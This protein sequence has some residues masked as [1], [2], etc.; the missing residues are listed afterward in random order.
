MLFEGVLI[1]LKYVKIIFFFAQFFEL[2]VNIFSEDLL[3]LEKLCVLL[4]DQRYR[5]LLL[6][7]VQAYPSAFLNQPEDLLRFHVDHLGDTS[8]HNKE[9]RVV[10]V[11]LD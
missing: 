10:D 3:N 9:V 2:R 6:S 8:L 4:L 5:L 1:T 11:K 7:L